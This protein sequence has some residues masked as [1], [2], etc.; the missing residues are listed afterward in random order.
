MHARIIRLTK[1]LEHLLESDQ[2]PDIHKQLIAATLLADE[3]GEQL[4]LEEMHNEY[5]SERE[6]RT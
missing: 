5:I 1:C 6:S 2:T 4:M 3:L